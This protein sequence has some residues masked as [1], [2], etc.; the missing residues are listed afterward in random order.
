MFQYSLARRFSPRDFHPSRSD[1]LND[2]Q[3]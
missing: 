3:T 1:A 2:W